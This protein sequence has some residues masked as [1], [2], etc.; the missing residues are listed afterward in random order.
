MAM[1]LWR[2]PAPPG[3]FA[4]SDYVLERNAGG[5]QLARWS[6]RLFFPSPKT[7]GRNPVL[8]AVHSAVSGP[9]MPEQSLP[10]P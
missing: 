6:A 10:I 7:L 4:S 5:L 2:N 3:V 9:L 1:A 8:W